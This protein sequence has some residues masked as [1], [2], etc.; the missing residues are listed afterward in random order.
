MTFDVNISN[1]RTQSSY[2]SENPAQEFS[3]FINTHRSLNFR[4]KNTG[5]KATGVLAMG[6]LEYS[7]ITS[8]QIERTKRSI[9]YMLYKS[10]FK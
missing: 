8:I 3:L 1:V 9:E 5:S 2:S 7:I 4:Q 6:K 10:K